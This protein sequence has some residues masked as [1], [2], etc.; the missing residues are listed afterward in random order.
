MIFWRIYNDKL[1]S[2]K[3]VENL[4]FNKSE[5]LYI[6][7]EYLEQQSF[8]ISRS[9]L[10]IGDWGVISAM[11]RL[12]KQK[13]P[14]CKVYLPSE[15]LL[16]SLFKPYSFEWLKSWDNPYETVKFI[17]TNNPYVDGY[18]D[19]VRGDIYHDHYRIYDPLNPE[20][21]LLEQM[22]DFWQF[23]PEEFED[24]SPELYFTEEE[25]LEGDKIIE[26]VGK[27]FGTLLI[28][29]RFE[30]KRDYDFIKKALDKYHNLPYFYW[31]KDKNILS[32]FDCNSVYDFSKVPIRIQMYIKTQSKVI[33]G[34]MSGADII[35]PRYTKVYMA[36]R[37]G[38]FGS[39]IVRGELIINKQNI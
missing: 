8:T 12:L 37:E 36:P 25:R 5:G 9:C 11:P 10:G 35:F 1:Y 21:P 16:E 14:D 2:V 18:V 23:T 29:N 13:Y 30:F 33:I 32:K 3:Q 20:T 17:F 31:I 38:G 34:S 22:L 27:E 4:G 28:S 15:K 24:S 39:N 7:N 19:S 26:N 6:P